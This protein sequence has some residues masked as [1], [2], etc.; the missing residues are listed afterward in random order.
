VPEGEQAF[1][2]RRARLRLQ[3]RLHDRFGFSIRPDFGI[4]GPEID[5]AYVEARLAPAARVR[6]GRFKVPVGLENRQSSTGL[7]HVERGVPTG[8]V[9]GRDVG[10]MLHGGVGGGR[11][12]YA[13]GAFNG[14][15]GASGPGDDVDDAVEGAARFFLTPFVEGDGPLEGLG[16]GGGGTLGSVTGTRATPALLSLRT[17]GRQT[18]FRY[19]A[20]VVA[21]GQRRRVAPQARLF[22]GPLEVLGEYTVTSQEVR[23]GPVAETL[24]HR[25][26]QVSTAVVVTGER[27]QDGAVVPRDPFAAGAG[28]GAFEIGARVQGVSF[29]DD[30]F[31]VFA[32]PSSAASDATAYGLTASWYPTATVRVML[33]YERTRLGTTGSASARE[34]EHLLLFRTQLAF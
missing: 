28:L 34:A 1:V 24:T 3:G 10:V 2:L 9:P 4:G 31:P 7:M 16:I 11:V 21:D 13:V 14:T 5:D 26:W 32:P 8:L 20:G 6:M 27:A 19:R 12:H 22:A 25:A 33:G 17:T 18:V 15:P 29:D 23:L 30:T